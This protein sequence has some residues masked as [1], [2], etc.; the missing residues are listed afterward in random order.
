MGE[1]FYCN[2]GAFIILSV[3]F[4]SAKAVPFSPVPELQ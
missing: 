1:V 2:S 3:Y 4:N